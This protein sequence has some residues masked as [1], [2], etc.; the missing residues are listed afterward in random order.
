L[1]Y[2]NHGGYGA[3]PAPV[4]VEQQRLR[5]RI[6]RNPTRFFRSD[7]AELL[8]DARTR[9][10][11]FLHADPDGVVFVANATTGVQTVLASLDLDASSE[12]VT[13]DH[14]YVGVRVQLDVL[15]RRTGC[16]VKVVPLALPLRDPDEI[17][18]TVAAALSPATTLLVIDQVASP[19]GLVFPVAD[20]AA[21]AHAHGVAVLVDAAHAV[22][23]LPVDVAA[24]DVD[25]WVGNLHKW[26]CAPK[27]AAVLSVAPRWR[28]RVRPLVPST[29]YDDGL[30]PSF[31]WTGTSDPTP[32]IAALS[33]CDYFDDLGWATVRQHNNALAASGARMIAAALNTDLPVSDQLSGSMRI[34]DLG[35]MLEPDA[36]RR[37]EGRLFD[38][39]R[40]EVPITAIDGHRWVRVSAQ[41]YNRMADYELLAAVL[42][43]LLDELD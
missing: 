10:A 42:P 3:V 12:I 13:T 39:H 19:T 37:L 28:D 11:A 14:A 23:M 15:A 31:D 27:S 38:T 24:L 8:G 1:S 35:R 18:D 22:G 9:L 29:Q 4:A 34:I 17:V 32:V 33:A 36:A 21:A 16:V 7:L 26:L 40:I 5:A 30:R 25:F 2:L 41:L 43:S 6:E 20:I